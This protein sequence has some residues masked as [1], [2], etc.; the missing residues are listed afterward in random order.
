MNMIDKVAEAIVDS[1]MKTEIDLTKRREWAKAAIE[2]MLEPTEEMLYAA[3]CASCNQDS[4]AINVWR[5]MID[6]ALKE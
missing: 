3:Q 1:F 5:A 6:E 4:D 2:A